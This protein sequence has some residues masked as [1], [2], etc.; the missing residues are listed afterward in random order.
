M[1]SPYGILLSLIMLTGCFETRQEQPAGFSPDMTKSQVAAMQW[2]N[3]TD[4]A[5]VKDGSLRI[6]ANRGT[7]FFNNPED[8]SISHSAPFLYTTKSG[9]FIATALVEPDF[10]S[11]WNAVALMVHINSL[12][13]IKFAFENSDATGPG[14]VSVV[15][16]GTSDDANGPVL[17][18][19]SHLWLALVRKDNNY[20]LHWSRDGKAYQMARLTS[21]KPV[22]AVKIGIEAQSP[23]GEKATHRI[24]SFDLSSKTVPDLR[25]YQR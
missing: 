24:H 11:Q 23:V 22:S 13:W 5:T 3:P 15:T 9:D 17:T 7:D 14:I 6:T 8:G 2:L 19:V 21:M 12:N 1:R 10:S 4:S 20:A 25:N 16:K 18:G